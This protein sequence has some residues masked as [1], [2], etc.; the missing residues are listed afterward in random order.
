MAYREA[1]PMATPAELAKVEQKVTTETGVFVL[2]SVVAVII[3]VC[4]LIFG[5]ETRG[6]SVEDIGNVD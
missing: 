5:V 2:I 3:G 4:I 1:N 6:E